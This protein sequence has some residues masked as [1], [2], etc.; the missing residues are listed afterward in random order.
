MVVHDLVGFPCKISLF[1]F[2][3]V[4]TFC[5]CGAIFS[6]H[7]DRNLLVCK[8][9]LILKTFSPSSWRWCPW[10]LLGN[11]GVRDAVGREV[12]QGEWASASDCV[13]QDLPERGA[14]GVQ[15]P[16]PQRVVV[17]SKLNISFVIVNCFLGIDSIAVSLFCNFNR[18]EA[19]P[20]GCLSWNQMY[21]LDRVRI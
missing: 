9:M 18:S 1:R 11:Q 17:L 21:I 7:T 13:D 8:L 19:N 14:W 15:E 12:H 5:W 3:S 2:E 4:N 20:W 16:F 10:D 6:L